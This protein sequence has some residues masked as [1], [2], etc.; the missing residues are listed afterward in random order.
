[1]KIGYVRVSTD[2]QDEEFQVLALEKAGCDLVK[3]DRGVSARTDPYTRPAFSEAMNLASAGDVLVVWRLDQLGRSQSSI[4][5][6]IDSLKPR[7]IELR[8]LV[9][10]IDTTTAM[11]CGMWQI[12]GVFAELERRLIQERT[13]AGMAAAKSRGRHVG[14]PRAL[15]DTQIQHAMA[16]VESGRQSISGIAALFG[17]NRKTVARSLKRA[18]SSAGREAHA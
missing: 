16:M 9:E 6:T 14:R 3:I 7:G 5:A 10:S 1:M 13:K 17:C 12:I 8:S 11:G 15:S 18:G 4:I 2:D